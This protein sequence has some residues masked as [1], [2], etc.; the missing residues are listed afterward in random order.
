MKKSIDLKKILFYILLFAGI[1]IR[2]YRFGS[3]PEGLNQDEAFAGYEAFSL[4]NYGIDSHGYINPVYF[5]SWGSG[6]NTLN[7]YLMIPFMKIFGVNEFSVRL[8]QFILSVATLPVFYLFLK[9]ISGEKCALLGLFLLAISPWHIMLSKWGLESNL[10]PSLV[11]F[12]M[13]FLLKGE[14][15]NRYYLLSAF[16]YGLSLYA[17]ATMWFF[18]PLVLLVYVIYAMKNKKIKSLKMAL[19]SVIILFFMAL[20]LILFVL[21]NFGAINEIKTPFFSIPKLVVMRSGEMSLL[22]IFKIDTYKNLFRILFL[23]EDGNV[24]NNAGNVGI[25][26]FLSLPFMITGFVKS[27]KKK[28]FSLVL[29]NFWVAIFVSLL[30]WNANINK[31]N[32]IH[33]PVIA[34]TAFGLE[35]ALKNKKALIA[36]I[37]AYVLLFGVFSNYYYT[38]YTEKFAAFSSAGLKEAA[39]RVKELKGD[40]YV[41]N[42]VQYPALLF[43]LGQDTNEYLETK[44]Y[45]NYPSPYMYINKFDRYYFTNV[46]D[47]CEHGI[48]ILRKDYADT[49]EKMGYNV[50][51]YNNIIIC[52]KNGTN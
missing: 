31:I 33:L 3:I 20:P 12:G 51:Y 46:L 29:I 5:V 13:Y 18:V 8:P 38:D 28:E 7:S 25:Y 6:M 16:F 52:Y 47:V 40:V 24:W 50:E 42:F 22:N 37:S 26:Y 27:F 11:L 19:L 2:L 43:Y 45:I 10:A 9:K 1:F 41:D 49:F 34:I 14:E 15:D 39:E 44:E 48:Y 23:Q 36:V 17:Y 21:I 35:T 30:M 32:F 4:L